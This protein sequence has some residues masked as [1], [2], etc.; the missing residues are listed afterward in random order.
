MPAEDYADIIAFA[1]DFSGNDAAI[2]DKVRQMAADPPT[3]I[4][5]I[6]FYGAEDYPPRHRL[7]LA[8]VSLL[9]NAQKLYSVED[10]YTAEIFS[11]WQD[12]NVISEKTLPDAAR[13]VF[14]PL[15]IGEQPPGDIKDYHRVV[16]EKYAEATRE[17]EKTIADDGRVLLSVDATDGDTML[18]ALVSPE[19]AERWRDK[20]L[21]EH[22]G[23]Y[24]GVRSPMWGRFW[25][26]LNYSTRGMM[27]PEDRRG[28]PPGTLER[29]DALPFAK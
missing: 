14:G 8:T 28:I 18:F 16:W 22:E 6:G 20:A 26:Y 23:Y 7:F 19:I 1:S 27:A 15:I 21:S 24:A 5:T 29:A 13:I 2:I 11:I 25:D 9:D 3:D 4:E 17:L 12:D 10:K